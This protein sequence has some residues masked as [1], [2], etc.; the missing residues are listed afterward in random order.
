MR[1]SIR[2][3]NATLLGSLAGMEIS[4]SGPNLP[5]ELSCSRGLT[6]FPN[7]DLFDHLPI[8][9]IDFLHLPFTGLRFCDLT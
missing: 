5:C 8:Q 1:S 3:L 7:P 9:V 2:P 6:G 4:G